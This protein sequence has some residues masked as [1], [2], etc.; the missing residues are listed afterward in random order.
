MGKRIQ[1]DDFSDLS[2]SVFQQMLLNIFLKSLKQKNLGS[3][4]QNK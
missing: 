1:K 3:K 4:L 2:I